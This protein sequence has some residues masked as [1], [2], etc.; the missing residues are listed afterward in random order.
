MADSQRFIRAEGKAKNRAIRV[1]TAA[2][3]NAVALTTV[4]TAGTFSTVA[5]SALALK[6]SVNGTD[7]KIPLFTA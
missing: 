3:T 2:F 6:L 7:Y 4:A 1:D 5:T